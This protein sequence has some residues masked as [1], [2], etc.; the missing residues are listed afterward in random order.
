MTDSNAI[1]TYPTRPEFGTYNP[2]QPDSPSRHISSTSTAM[3]ER[4]PAAGSQTMTITNEQE[5][6]HQHEVAIAGMLHLQGGGDQR[7]DRKVKWR[8]GVV[9]NEGMGKKTSKSCCI[10]HKP[11]SFDDSDSSDYSTSDEDS[12]N[13]PNRYERQPKYRNAPNNSSSGNGGASGSKS[14]RKKKH[15]HHRHDHYHESCDGHCGDGPGEASSGGGASGD[16]NLA[17]S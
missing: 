3:R 8:T 13:V 2:D 5:G 12:P 4:A 7:S 6:D 1:N 15:S 9:D 16:Q 17:S 11:Y 14:T 10:Y